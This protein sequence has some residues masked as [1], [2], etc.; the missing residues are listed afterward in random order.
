MN[1][2]SFQVVYEFALDFTKKRI[3][4]FVCEVETGWTRFSIDSGEGEVINDQ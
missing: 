1:F 3:A 2:L 4:T